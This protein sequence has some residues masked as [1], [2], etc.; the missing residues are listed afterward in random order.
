MKKQRIFK[1]EPYDEVNDI[2]FIK[3]K[4]WWIFYSHVSTGTKSDLIKWAKKNGI[5]I[6]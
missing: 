6:E 2:W 3:E 1:L 5:L 4:T